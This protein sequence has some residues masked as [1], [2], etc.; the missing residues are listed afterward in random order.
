MDRR[1]LLALVL[2]ALI[3]VAWTS[4]FP[5]S[6]RSSTQRLQPVAGSVDSA[7]APAGVAGTAGVEAGSKEGSGPL[8]DLPATAQQRGSEPHISRPTGTSPS[9]YRLSV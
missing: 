4:I 7:A 9:A 6:R 3:I 8:D 1:T 5:P 2:S